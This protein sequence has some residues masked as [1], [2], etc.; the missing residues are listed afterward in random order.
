V[1]FEQLTKTEAGD[2][3]GSAWAMTGKKTVGSMVVLF[4]LLC[5]AMASLFKGESKVSTVND[6]AGDYYAYHSSTTEANCNAVC[7]SY[8]GGSF[9]CGTACSYAIPATYGFCYGYYY[10]GCYYESQFSSIS[11]GWCIV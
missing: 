1:C 6:K 9:N 2:E 10:G 3:A 11:G 8:C 5:L 4:V 7:S